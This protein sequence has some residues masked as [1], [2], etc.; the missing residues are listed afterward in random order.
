MAGEDRNQ[1]DHIESQ[2]LKNGRSFSFFQAFRL[3]RN[4]LQENDGFA[5][6]SGTNLSFKG[7]RIRPN[8]SLAFPATDVEKIEKLGEKNGYELVANILGLY[9]TCSPLP[10][11]YTEELFED[12][13]G[14]NNTAK[15]LV[16]I[17]NQRLYELLFAGWGK[18]RTMQKILEEKSRVDEERLFSLIG[19][20]EEQLRDEI[21]NP[22]FLLRYTGLFAMGPR[23]AVGLETILSDALGAGKVEIIQLAEQKGAIPDDQKAYL[24]CNINLGA[25]SLLGSQSRTSTGAFRIKIGPVSQDVFR[26]FFPGK[27]RHDRLVLLTK[28]YLSRPFEYVVEVRLDR[29]EKPETTRPGKKKWSSLGLDTWL[30]SDTGPEEYLLEFCHNTG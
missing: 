11:F 3:L 7:L 23:S 5:G 2:L 21:E 8:L 20:G 10:T 17:I 26:S 24:G 30:F 12:T 19:M 4:L 29:E 18:Y 25:N 15:D 16:D 27:T 1:A 22:Y 28:L 6:K 14:G 13:S 9:G